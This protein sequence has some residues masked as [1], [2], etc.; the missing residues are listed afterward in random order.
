MLEELARDVTGWP[1][2]VVEFFERLTWTQNLEHLRPWSTD[3]PDIRRT[4]VGDRVHG[5][6]DEVSHTVDV[7]RIG[8]LE[9]WYGIRNIGFFL[10]RLRDYPL[11]DV[12]TRNVGPAWRRTFSPLGTTAPLFSSWR[13][14]GDEAGLAT[15]RFIPAPIRAAAFFEDLRAAAPGAHDTELYGDMRQRSDASIAVY[16][17]GVYVPADKIVCRNLGHWTTTPQPPDDKIAIDARRGRL[18]VGALRPVHKITVAYRYGFSGDLGGGPYERGKWLADPRGYTARIT[19]GAAATADKAT[20]NAALADW[21]ANHRAEPTVI[22]ILDDRT[23]ELAPTIDLHCRRA[24]GHPGVVKGAAAHPADRRRDRSWPGRRPGHRSRSAAC[25]SKVASGSIRRSAGCASCTPTLV[26]GPPGHRG[27]RRA[28]DRCLHHDHREL[29]RCTRSTPRRGSRSLSAS[30]GRSG[31]PATR[32]GSGSSIRSSTARGSVAC[33]AWPSPTRSGRR[34]P[35]ASGP[36]ATIERIDHPWRDAASGCSTLAASRSSSAASQ[37]TRTEEGCLR[38]SYV[39]PGSRTPATVPLPARAGAS[40]RRRGRPRGGG[41]ERNDAD[42]RP[43]QG[44]RRRRRAP[45][46]ARLHDHRLR[47]ARLRP[48]PARESRPDPDRGRGRLGDGCVQPP[49]AATSAR[50]TSGSG[51]RSTCRSVSRPDSSTSPEGEVMSGDY[52]RDSFHP[53]RAFAA[54][55]KQQGRVSTDA[56]FNELIELIDRRWRAETV[57]IIGCCAVPRSTPDGFKLVLDASAGGGYTLGRGRA[58]VDGL[59]AECRGDPT[60]A[61]VTFDPTLGED[62]GGPT[63]A[64]NAQPFIYSS[65]VNLFPDPFTVPAAT[66]SLAY[67]DVWE[68]EVRRH[69][70]AGPARG[71]DRWTR[72]HDP[73]AD[74][75]AGQVRR[76]DR[77]GRG[78]PADPTTRPG[79]PSPRPPRS[80]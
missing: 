35:N 8:R 69:L 44:H 37:A 41:L 3:A 61:K 29:G 48:A 21:A 64:I 78:L 1:A 54:V 5:P 63:L 77:Q 79:W 57:D 22:E 17:D 39:E 23:Y 2:H 47:P 45:D 66:P 40:E 68:R 13:R 58:Y 71:R 56:D 12:M 42:R 72:H 18:L 30:A 27:G 76:L 9:G 16:D 28:R 31:C 60:A 7:R 70:G 24:A 55:L 4:D 80:G 74:R 75:V 15:E 73:P 11:R 25:S 43:G 59:Q 14:E 52:T 34:Q 67:L 50:P 10:F 33:A 19:V 51:W 38:F 20:L 53:E 32:S 62:F 6:W 65:V 49:Q 46:G 26:P 36:R